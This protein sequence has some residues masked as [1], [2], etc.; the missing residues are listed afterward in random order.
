MNLTSE[1]KAML[2]GEQ[3]RAAQKAMEILVALGR[4]FDADRLVPIGSAQVA[5]VSYLNLGDEGLEFLEEMATDGKV[6]VLS[7][8]N[9]AGMDLED[10]RFQGIPESFAE[11]QSR[12]IA[13]F[14][15]MGIAPTC[16]CTPYLA[17]NTPGAGEHIAW[18]ESSAVCYANS[19]LGARTNREG[20]PAALAAALAG[21]TPL[22]GLHLDENRQAQVRVDLRTPVE[23]AYALSVLGSVV[24]RR[25]GNRI[26]LF[27]GLGE[28]GAEGLKSL[29]AAL[30]TFG[31]T[32]LFHVEGTTPG[33]WG[34]TKEAVVVD[35]ADMEE[36]A[37]RMDDGA[38]ADLVS[39]GCPHASLEEIRRAAE[40]LQGRRV[41]RP[42]WITTSRPVKEAAARMGYTAVVEEAGALVVC[43]T[44]VAVAPLKGTFH[45]LATDSAK[46]WYYGQGMNRLR[47][48][49][50]PTEACLELAL[51]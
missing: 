34:E 32:A 9:P 11:Q 28:I 50:L 15:R 2:A 13:A 33:T 36:A 35:R 41:R 7:M 40:L 8:L 44:C 16:T 31:G 20:G 21:R 37:A 38:E 1:E 3:G 25:I 29:G 12:V 46:M 27:T 49:L 23:S 22:Y 10:W 4:I 26:P 51:Q 24:G 17:G 47:T 30:A 45:A 18:S 6:Q 14:Q 42:L 39:I 48:R 5:G 19:V 43:D